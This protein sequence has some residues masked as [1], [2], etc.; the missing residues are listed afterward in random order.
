MNSSAIRKF[1]IIAIAAMV[2]ASLPAQK[3]AAAG[4]NSNGSQYASC[5][6]SFYNPDYYNWLA[7][8]NDC[9]MSLELVA[10]SILPESS[11][12]YDCR[13]FDSV[14]PGRYGSTGLSRSEV[15]PLGG[16]W[17]YTC[18]VGYHPVDET[19]QYVIKPRLRYTCRVD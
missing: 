1:L 6:S 8:R 4:E 17:L 2:M 5:F 16:F 7:F 11:G 9:S 19:G 12:A 13:T 15:R 10:C 18:P 14:R 3:A